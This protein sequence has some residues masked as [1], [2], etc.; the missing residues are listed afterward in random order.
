MVFIGISGVYFLILFL[1]SRYKFEA[2]LKAWTC[3]LL[4]NVMYFFLEGGLVFLSAFQSVLLNMLPFFA[5]Y[6][7]AQKDV[8][9]RKHLIAF[10][11]VILPLVI[12]R[13]LYSSIDLQEES[14]REN[15]VDNTIYMFFGLLPFVFL[16]KRNVIMVILLLLLWIFLIQSGKRAALGAGIITFVVLFYY[17][18]NLIRNRKYF[19]LYLVFSTMFF[20][21]LSFWGYSYFL[22]NEFLVRR[23]EL[24]LMGDS[25][26]RDR[27]ANVVFKSWYEVDDIFMYL[28]GQGFHTSAKVSSHVSHNDWLEV[29]A[30][31]GLV[32]TL[33]YFSIFA[34]AYKKSRLK[35]WKPYKKAAFIC[36][37]LIALLA[38]VT[39]RWFWSAF[40]YSQMLLLPYLMAT[41]NRE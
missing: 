35:D 16:F 25:A 22:E 18:L 26:G 21:I 7:F 34:S 14:G 17:Q 8:L 19:F 39:S 40:P 6:F 37:I 41:Y 12:F 27:L 3:F 4:L 29:L 32:G 13:F 10:F 24:M 23:I 28:F 5:F 2:F 31:Y 9:K 30:S 1:S 36:I 38:S 33:V 11:I 15:V 20:F